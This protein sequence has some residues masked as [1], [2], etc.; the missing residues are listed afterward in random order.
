MK[1]APLVPVCLCRRRLLGLALLTPLGAGLSACSDKSANARSLAPVEIDGASSCALDG[2]L[3]ADYGGP[4]AQIHYGDDKAPVFLCDTLEMF[5]QLLRP[6][7]VRQVLAVYVQD[8]GRADWDM[9]QGH[10][11][12]AGSAWYVRGSRRKGSMGPTLASFAQQA[13]AQKFAA[14]HGGTV[15]AYAQIK[16]EMVDL[17]GGSKFETRM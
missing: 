11:I 8:M 2:M 10:W 7:V 5:H 6:E 3:L 12:A 13:E 14:E 9:P 17:S 1:F 4:K 16:P 15:L